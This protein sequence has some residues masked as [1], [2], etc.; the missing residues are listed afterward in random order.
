MKSEL[1]RE[2]DIT[3]DAAAA[4]KTRNANSCDDC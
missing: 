4:V 2:V 3:R 1:N